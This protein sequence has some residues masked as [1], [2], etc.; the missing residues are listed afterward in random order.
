MPPKLPDNPDRNSTS[1]G[2]V[3]FTDEA[4]MMRVQQGDSEAYKVLFERHQGRVY[5]YL[6]R[7][8]RSP[9]IAAD[10][11]Q[12][13]FLRLYRARNTWQKG[14]PVRPWLFGIAV[15]AAKDHARKVRRLPVEVELSP[16]LQGEGIRNPVT[17]MDLEQAIAGL[18]DHMRDAF[19]LGAVEGFDHNEV[20][21][22]LDI[23]PDNA[24]ARISRARA[25]LRKML[26][27]EP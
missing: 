17:K 11:Y 5:G 27:G 15:N 9:E 7:R 22:Q 2:G 26:G 21:A 25:Q 4:L 20:A 3:E 6:L 18:P 12:E 1:S 23:S 24:R 13:T 14:R 19:L 8:T 10:L 16:T